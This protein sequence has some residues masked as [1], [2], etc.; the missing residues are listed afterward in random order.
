MGVQQGR[1]AGMSKPVRKTF[2]PIQTETQPKYTVSNLIYELEKAS[3]AGCLDVVVFHTKDRHNLKVLS[4]Y[5]SPFGVVN[6][7]L[8][9]EGD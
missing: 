5:M 1:Q 4:I 8:G 6:I 9:E 3:N 7:D 2:I